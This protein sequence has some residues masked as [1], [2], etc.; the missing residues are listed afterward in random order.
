[1]AVGSPLSAPS[2][3]VFLILWY[4]YRD[5]HG[6]SLDEHKDLLRQRQWKEEEFEAG[7]QKGVAPRDGSKHFLKYEALLRRALAKGEVRSHLAAVPSSASCCSM[8][9]VCVRVVVGRCLWIMF[10]VGLFDLLVDR[11]ELNVTSAFC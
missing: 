6:I 2:L 5:M 9:F 10:I 7:F 8:W 4:R 1:M 11:A 3:L